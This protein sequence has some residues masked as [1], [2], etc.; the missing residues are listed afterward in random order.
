MMGSS[1]D[2]D[3]QIKANAVIGRLLARAI[4]DVD[5]RATLTGSHGQGISSKKRLPSGVERSA[6]K[7]YVHEEYRQGKNPVLLFRRGG[8]RERDTHT[9][10]LWWLQW[11]QRGDGRRGDILRL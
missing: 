8:V 2:G 9:P 10:A 1:G 6:L 11:D 7:S 3:V 4:Q 5:A